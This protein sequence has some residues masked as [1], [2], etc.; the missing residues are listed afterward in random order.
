MNISAPKYFVAAFWKQIEHNGWLRYQAA[1]KIEM[2]YFELL[3]LEKNNIFVH[4]SILKSVL[5]LPHKYQIF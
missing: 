2:G 5:L 1:L 4:P 3:L